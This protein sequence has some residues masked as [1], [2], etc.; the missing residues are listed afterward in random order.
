MVPRFCPPK[1]EPLSG[2]RC[3]GKKYYLG[4]AIDCIYIYL[5]N[6]VL[7]IISLVLV[8]MHLDFLHTNHLVSPVRKDLVRRRK[9]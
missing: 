4:L 9:K 8:K 3:S 1:I 7:C 2:L 5:F 6:N